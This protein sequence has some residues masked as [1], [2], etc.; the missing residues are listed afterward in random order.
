MISRAP[1]ITKRT[2]SATKCAS[3]AIP[4]WA[5]RQTAF[6]GSIRCALAIYRH[7]A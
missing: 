2:N 7:L 6:T 3:L 1:T 4:R 5:S